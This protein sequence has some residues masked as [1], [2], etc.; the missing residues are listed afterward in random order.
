MLRADITVLMKKREELSKQNQAI[1]EENE[2]LKRQAETYYLTKKSEADE[3]ESKAKKVYA[4]SLVA[5][6]TKKAEKEKE[7]ETSYIK[8]KLKDTL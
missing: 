6:E 5:R 7:K 4:D 1:I 2:N 3:I 8:S